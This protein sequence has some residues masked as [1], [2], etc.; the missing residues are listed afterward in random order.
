[1]FALKRAYLPIFLLLTLALSA[2][3][4]STAVA[5]PE[6]PT[7]TPLPPAPQLER[8]TFTVQLGTIERLLDVTGTITP[9]D[10]TRIGFK[11]EGRIERVLVARGDHVKK[12][13]LLAELQQDDK[14]DELHDAEDQYVQAQR[15]LASAQKQQSAKVAQA[16]LQLVQAQEDLTRVQPGGPDDPIRKAQQDA[17]RAL[18]D[19]QR[20]AEDQAEAGSLTK[21]EAEDGLTQASEKLQDAQKAYQKAYWDNDWVERHGTDP[22]QPNV[23]GADGKKRGNK[24]SDAQKQ[25]YKDKLAQ[26]ERDM[27][28]AEQGIEKAQAA[29]ERANQQEARKNDAANEKL[30]DA[31][32]AI[33]AVAAQGTSKELI[34]AQR[35]LR[36]AQLALSAAQQGSYNS[37]MKAID[38]AKRAVE[39]ARKAVDDGQITAPQDGEV[40]AVSIAEGDSAEAFTPVFE[41]ADP[42]QLEVSLDLSG[43]QMRQLSEGQP[44]QVNLLARPDVP[45]PALIRLLPAPYGS[46]GS[47]AVAEQD[48]TTRVSVS[49][50]KGQE[51]IAGNKVKV[52]IVLERKENV[53]WLPPDAVRAFEGRRFVVVREG[54]RERR[55]TVA[56][57]IQT[58]DKLEITDG[59][60]QGDIIVGQ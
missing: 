29:I 53:L 38:S 52:Q 34:T 40:L 5:Q 46:G 3:G 26:A 54:E 48:K 43:E 18:R 28:D 9:V 32:Q 11:R 19:A 56:V 45:M 14:I 30:Q 2:C 27:K 24:L 15:D 35:S 7:P 33:D 6:P 39:K 58:D 10:L 44:A 41:I 1:M 23:V 50:L 13:D 49:D 51:L 37:E 16:Q 20:D 47:G 17:Q 25:E 57:G 12:G 42:S 55:Q 36:E 59:V 31:Q 8:P 4:G 21:T 22:N 60:K